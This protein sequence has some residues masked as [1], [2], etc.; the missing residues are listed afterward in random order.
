MKIKLLKPILSILLILTLMTNSAFGYFDYSEYRPLQISRVQATLALLEEPKKPPTIGDAVVDLAVDSATSPTST[1]GGAVVSQGLNYLERLVGEADKIKAS[2]NKAE[3]GLSRL[4]EA[5]A[6]I[7]K[8]LSKLKE[9][10]KAWNRTMRS[11]NNNADKIAANRKLTEGLFGKLRN[12][13]GIK[14]TGTALS[15]YGMY[16]D[17]EA[18]LKGEYK[19]NHSS[20]RFLRDTLLGSNVAINGFLLT[21]WGQI[22]VIK[23]GGELFALGVGVSKDFVTSDTFAAY[24]NSKNNRVLNVADEIID[25]TNDYWT[26]T[27]EGWITRWYQYTGVHPTP[28]QLA[29][30]QQRHQQWLDRRNQGL[31]RKPGDNVGA[32]KPNIYIY[33]TEVTEVT[34]VFDMPGLLETVIPDYLDRWQVTAYPDGSMMTSDGKVYDYLFYESMTWPALYQTDEGWI[35]DAEHRNEQMENILIAYGFTEKERNDFL[36]YWNVKLDPD[37]DYAVYPQL[38]E[39]VDL[40]MPVQITPEPEFLF[41]L[42]FV[43]DKESMPNTEPVIEPM[44]RFGYAIVEWGGVILEE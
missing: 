2:I 8:S 22:P 3:K 43:F 14:L 18:L 29:L 36:D 5:K 41:R 12:L 32:Y 28:E 35:I 6:N 7:E 27:F 44:N 10:S 24:M 40:A 16:T 11:L 30:A 33:P 42:W 17:T 38:T 1:G 26:E 34:V 19:H 13:K 25:N 20:M 31:G 15:V 21:P 23:Q 37:E 4:L 9:G 39:T